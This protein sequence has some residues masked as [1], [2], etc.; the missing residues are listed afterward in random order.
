[1]PDPLSSS[2]ASSSPTA[3]IASSSSSQPRQTRSAFNQ[4]QLADLELAESVCEASGKEPYRALLA[5]REIT[6]AVIQTLQSLCHSARRATTVALWGDRLQ[7]EDRES[8]RTSESQID[9]ALH[10]IQAAA[11]QKYARR[12]PSKLKDYFIGERLDSNER[13][14]R[15]GAFSVIEKL[16]PATG[17]DLASAPDK[18]PGITVAKINVLRRLIGLPAIGA[19]V[20]GSS[21]SASGAMP[22]PADRAARDRMISEINDRRMEVQFAIDGAFPPS[23]PASETACR[24]FDLP[25]RRAMGR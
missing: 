2:S 4:T 12:D 18:L 13:T 10:E 24:A 22:P 25:L 11:K 7:N 3:P 19:P 21:S 1:M 5:E 9:A 8:E 14:L 20:T 23:Q 16:T 15:Q 17:T 6:P